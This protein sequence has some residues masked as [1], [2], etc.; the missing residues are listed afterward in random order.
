MCTIKCNTLK[1]DVVHDVVCF[2]WDICEVMRSGETNPSR[3]P[4]LRGV[5]G[6]RRRSLFFF[7]S[8]L[9]SNFKTQHLNGGADSIYGGVGVE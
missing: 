4:H 7:L 5:H 3:F 1:D 8:G 9:W 2:F 6:R